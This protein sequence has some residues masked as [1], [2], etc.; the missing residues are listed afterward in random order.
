MKPRL[1]PVNNFT[2]ANLDKDFNNLQKLNNSQLLDVSSL[3]KI[4]KFSKPVFYPIIKCNSWPEA[5][6]S[7]KNFLKQLGFILFKN[8]T[9]QRSINLSASFPGEIDHAINFDNAYSIIGG[10]PSACYEGPFKN[11]KYESFASFSD[12]NDG[13]DASIAPAA[14]QFISMGDDLK[15]IREV[16]KNGHNNRNGLLV[17]LHNNRKLK[18]IISASNKYWDLLDDFER[19]C[20][21][22]YI[23]GFED[24]IENHKITKNEAEISAW[25][26]DTKNYLNNEVGLG[27]I[28]KLGSSAPSTAFHFICSKILSIKENKMDQRTGRQFFKI[29]HVYN[30]TRANQF[31]DDLGFLD[32]E[33][34]HKFKF[35]TPTAEVLFLSN[36]LY[37]KLRCSNLLSCYDKKEF[38]R[39]FYIAPSNWHLS[40]I[41][42][43]DQTWWLDCAGRMGAKN[44][45]IFAQ[46]LSSTLDSIFNAYFGCGFSITNQDDSFV[47]LPNPETDKCFNGL[48]NEFGLIINET[49]TQLLRSEAEWAGYIFNQ[50]SMTLKLKPKRIEKIKT[51]A[52]LLLSSIGDAN[53]SICRRDVA[54]F[55]GCIHS[56][57]PLICGKFYHANPLLFWL[58]K[59]AYLFDPFYTDR[60]LHQEFY[61]ETIKLNSLCAFEIR[62]MLEIVESEVDYADIRRGLN[63]YL[64]ARIDEKV[65]DDHDVIFSDSSGDIMGFG[66]I[67]SGIKYSFKIGLDLEKRNSWSIN[68]KELYAAVLALVCYFALNLHS[69]KKIVLYVDNTCAQ[70]ILAGRKSNLKSVEIALCIKIVELLCFGRRL[71]IK[72]CPTHDNQWADI[73]SRSPSITDTIGLKKI[74]PFNLLIG[75]QNPLFYVLKEL[76]LAG[77]QSATQNMNK[78]EL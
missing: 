1:I 21:W 41:K 7:T 42:T 44:S 55:L 31:I 46:R 34:L 22:H 32:E 49:K 29:R 13:I 63:D 54:K 18:S 75:V 16:L 58:R 70:S 64:T 33:C 62:L 69:D 4:E 2:S 5:H 38:Y 3:S 23:A 56:C 39:Q 67:S 72:R 12:F 68:L 10:V 28:F 73:L 57:R 66:I 30:N 35:S 43:A 52:E 26:F 17:T 9:K 6:A 20:L 53:S 40:L 24:K 50:S 15:N 77:P 65:T 25:N 60:T 14:N 78:I 27:R 48:C 71:V 11:F 51:A 37:K 76:G 47:L 8:N 74:C 19:D 61:D 36:T 59:T 45:A